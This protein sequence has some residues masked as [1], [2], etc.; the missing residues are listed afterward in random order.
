MVDLPQLRAAIAV[1][2][3]LQA[4]G[5]KTTRLA[6]RGSGGT[7]WDTD[8][9][10]A[11]TGESNAGTGGAA[12]AGGSVDASFGGTAGAAGGQGGA[13]GTAAGGQSGDAGTAPAADA[14]SCADELI[15]APVQA[16]VQGI[17][18]GAFVP[19]TF[20]RL[21]HVA[22]TSRK[23]LVEHDRQWGACLWGVFVSAPNVRTAT[24]RTGLLLVSYGD[25]SSPGTLD[26]CKS[27][28]D[29]IP[30]NVE[31]G[32]VL[33]VIGEVLTYAPLAC[34]AT[35]QQMMV[36]L[37][38]HCPVQMLGAITPP[39]PAV[40]DANTADEI[41]RGT[42]SDLLKE[43][44][45]VLV[46]L[47]DV[48]ASSVDGGGILSPSGAIAFQQTSLE[49]HDA[50]FVNDLSGPGPEA[51]TKAWSYSGATHFSYVQGFVYLDSCTWSIC[52]R[53]RC[54]D[55]DPPSTDCVMSD[56]GP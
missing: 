4:C 49:A 45:G 23:F 5:G 7:S 26:P 29:A 44:G 30:D 53:N 18:Q 55:V 37:P 3:L 28:T 22:A 36:R 8:S 24:V 34:P 52:P 41:A 48:D 33:D 15:R 12:D 40:L 2:S 6:L 56:G 35:A 20:I 46:R 19:H 14:R 21:T 1:C 27:G 31:A 11:G 10:M 51:V 47:E 50:I 39:A 13:A 32:D 9:G 43:W 38:N 54:T 17:A 25:N 42:N 16:T